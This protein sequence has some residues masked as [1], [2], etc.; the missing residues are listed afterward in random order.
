MNV[1]FA[2]MIIPSFEGANIIT[3]QY[4][5]LVILELE[6]ISPM[7]QWSL[8]VCLSYMDLLLHNVSFIIDN[9]FIRG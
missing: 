6:R 2:V 1:Q 9:D 5:V 8:V 7:G 4:T 3:F